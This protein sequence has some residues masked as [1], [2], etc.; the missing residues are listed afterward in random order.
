[1]TTTSLEPDDYYIDQ[2]TEY[3]VFTELYHLKRGYCCG[4]KCRHCP[5]FPKYQK[6]NHK[7]KAPKNMNDEQL[8][9]HLEKAKK[10]A[11]VGFSKDPSKT[12][13]RVPK[14][15]TE[16]YQVFPVNPNATEIDGMK[17]FK[18]L[19]D[20][21]ESVDIVDVFR[22]GPQCVK[23][24]KD[25]LQM[26]SKPKLVWL[27]L[28]ITNAEAKQL[29]QENGIDFIEDACIYVEHERLLC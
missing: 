4:S 6:F 7:R 26:H 3:I 10:I 28:H 1:M 11:V 13:Y 25:V 5:F 9:E 16:F 29:A 17:C 23:V 8:K 22:P 20:I 2:D 15:L 24:M 14:Y 12:A 21:S 19:Q 27:Q 18:S